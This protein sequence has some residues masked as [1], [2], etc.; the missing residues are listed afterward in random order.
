MITRVTG[1]S[2]AARL[3]GASFDATYGHSVTELMG[4]GAPA[5]PPADFDER[6]A[7]VRTE[8]LAV[9]PA[10]EIGPWRSMVGANGP[11][12]VADVHLRS[13]RG[14]RLRGW[15]VRSFGELRRG[16]V[17]GHGYGGRA[18]PALELPEG[19]L[20]LQLVA[21][22]LPGSEVLGIGTA[23]ASHVLSGIGSFLTYSHTGAVADQ[24][25][26]TSALQALAPDVPLG[27]GG[28]SFG[29]G[30]GTLAAA[31]E[32]RWDALQV[33]VPS[34]GNHPLRLG[35]RCTGSGEAVRTYAQSHPGVRAVLGYVDA[36]TAAS[37]VTVPVLC[38]AA[39]ADPVVPPPGQ[40]AIAMSFAGPTWLHVQPGGHA[41][42]PGSPEDLAEAD[43]NV[44]EF[45]SYPAGS[46]WPR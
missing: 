34:F 12:E 42:W 40:F 38:V 11:V 17:L 2:G 21:R 30:I 39:A 33:T 24:W 5:D 7:V 6:W 41:E 26:G 14:V 8:A 46:V 45:W 13:W 15:L 44:A 18:A 9:D 29:G 37:R 27:Y 43:R 31:F 35:L 32:D 19:C 22:G 25:V 23:G 1:A 36:A 10:P 16:L 20:S 28:S 4:F 3:T